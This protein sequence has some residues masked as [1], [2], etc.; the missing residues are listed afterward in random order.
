ML[1]KKPKLS[2]L[3]LIGFNI[4]SAISNGHL[5]SI[6]FEDIYTAINDENLFELLDRKIPEY[7]KL[8]GFKL[9]AEDNIGFH[10]VLS[11]SS[12]A[13]EGSEDKLGYRNVNHGLLLLQSFIFNAI[14]MRD[15]T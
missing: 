4:N 9:S 1:E 15:W 6:S 5:D 8:E 12:G 13:F 11:Y 3:S 7:F 2:L 10:E 14:Q